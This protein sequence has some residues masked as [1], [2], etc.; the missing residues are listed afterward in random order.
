MQKKFLKISGIFKSTTIGRT[1]ECTTNSRTAEVQ[2]LPLHAKF[3]LFCPQ[4]FDLRYLCRD[5]HWWKRLFAKFKF[6]KGGH[7]SL[8]ETFFQ[9]LTPK[10]GFY[11]ILKFFSRRRNSSHF[12]CYC[13]FNAVFPDGLKK[14]QIYFGIFEN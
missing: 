11:I 9:G 6:P 2:A 14:R 7:P 1:F 5:D 3:E 10:H 8:T 12:F 4:T 13:F